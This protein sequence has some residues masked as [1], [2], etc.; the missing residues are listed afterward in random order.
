ME[1]I[2]HAVR[3]NAGTI[4]LI[5]TSKFMPMIRLAV[6]NWVQNPWLAFH[7]S[8]GFCIGMHLI[9]TAITSAGNAGTRYTAQVRIR[10]L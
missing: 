7:P 9:E 10:E 1:T 6:N 2:C 3:C 8:E 5:W 4:S